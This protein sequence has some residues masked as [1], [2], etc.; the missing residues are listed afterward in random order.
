MRYEQQIEEYLCYSNHIPTY[1]RCNHPY[2]CCSTGS[3]IDPGRPK[4]S[5]E[6]FGRCEHGVSATATPEILAQVIS[7]DRSYHFAH[8]RFAYGV[9]LSWK[10]LECLHAIIGSL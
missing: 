8:I 7:L 5:R 1:A 10:V 6:V 3:G 9:S 2:F 4:T